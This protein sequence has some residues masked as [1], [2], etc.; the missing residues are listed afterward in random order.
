MED[1]VAFVLRCHIYGSG[2]G[3]WAK[4]CGHCLNHDGRGVQSMVTGRSAL[5]SWT[6]WW[7]ALMYPDQI[8]ETKLSNEERQHLC[9]NLSFLSAA[10]FTTTASFGPSIQ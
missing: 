2:Y 3:F 10:G 4:L 8:R 7:A 1:Q 6:R 9:Q 5:F